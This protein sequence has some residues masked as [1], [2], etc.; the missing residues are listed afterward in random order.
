MIVSLNVQILNILEISVNTRHPPK[1]F[2]K[3]ISEISKKIEPN[4]E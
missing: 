3:C 4:T 1:D 2:T